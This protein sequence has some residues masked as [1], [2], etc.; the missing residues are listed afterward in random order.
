MIYLIQDFIEEPVRPVPESPLTIGY[1]SRTGS[2]FGANSEFC[3]VTSFVQHE[4]DQQLQIT[5][6]IV[7]DGLGGET[8]GA[9]ASNLAVQIMRRHFAQADSIDILRLLYNALRETNQLLYERGK[10]VSDLKGQLGSSLAVA[11][12]LDNRLYAASIGN[13]RIYLLRPGGKLIQITLDHSRKSRDRRAKQD[14][15]YASPIA[16]EL[17]R[18]LGQ[19]PEAALDFRLRLGPDEN[20]RQMLGNQGVELKPGDT[21]LLASDGVTGSLSPQKIESLLRRYPPRKAAEKLTRAAQSRRPD[22]NASAL[23]I[24][25][26]GGE[27][28]AGPVPPWRSLARYGAMG[29]LGLVLIVA[30][31]YGTI[32]AAQ[33][34]GAGPET[35]TPTPSAEPTQTPLPPRPTALPSQ[36]STP[37]Q[38]TTPSSTATET[39]SPSPSPIPTWTPIPWPTWTPVHAYPTWTLPR[40]TQAPVP[41]PTEEATDTPTEQPQPSDTPARATEAPSPPTETAVPRP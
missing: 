29:L 28:P 14:E 16:A 10:R 23:V 26:P 38:T 31:A 36:T 4:R 37:T 18:Y 20:D 25:V 33:L 12:V 15:G 41:E 1:H 13:C 8:F 6:G 9:E 35:A 22:E 7:A 3:G 11:A 17:E 19:A 30:L 34:W 24:Q 21:L 2:I 40:V 27:G 32:Q 39:P 5:L